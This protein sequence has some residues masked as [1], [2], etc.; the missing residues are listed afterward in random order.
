MDLADL[1]DTASVTMTVAELR[2]LIREGARPAG[3]EFGRESEG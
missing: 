3:P 2:R 1:P